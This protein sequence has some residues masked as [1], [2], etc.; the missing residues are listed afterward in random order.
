MS[1]NGNRFRRILRQSFA[2][3]LNLDPLHL[4][5]SPLPAYEPVFDWENERSMIFGQ[6]IPETHKALYGSG[7]KISLKVLSLAFRAG[8]VEPFY[9]TICL[10]NRERRDKLSEDF[11]FC[12]LPAEMRDPSSSCE[13]RDVFY[14]DAPS[15]SVC[16]LIQLEKP[17]TEKAGVTPS[18]YSLKEQ[19]SPSKY[20]I[21]ACHCFAGW[22]GYL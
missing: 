5:E 2:S 6:Q 19:V 16:L 22:F 10:Y 13:S 12:V 21:M 9:G 18:V 8:L 11:I 14:L 1:S 3:N 20:V 15:A 17:A 7:L 4:G